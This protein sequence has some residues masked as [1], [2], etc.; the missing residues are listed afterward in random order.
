M[1]GLDLI[2]FDCDGVLVDSERTTT[3]LLA[4]FLT[5]LGVPTTV[6]EAVHRYK[7]TDLHV[8]AARV[9]RQLGRP[10][11]RFIET[12]RERMGPALAADCPAMDGAPEALDAVE[13]AGVAWCVASNGPRSKMETTLRASGLAG[14]VDPARVFSAYEVGTWKPDP[15]L[16]L[17]AAAAM[18]VEPGA[19]VVVEDS[20]S[21]VRAALAAGMGVVAVSDLTPADRLREAGA[22]TVITSMRDLPGV[23]GICPPTVGA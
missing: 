9:E 22:G 10:V 4:Q 11:E 18:G 6:E 16:F 12:Y 17:A 19:C 20:V 7:G 21:G 8:V 13:R 14:R 2:I 1:D 23:L 5:E 15:G 3:R